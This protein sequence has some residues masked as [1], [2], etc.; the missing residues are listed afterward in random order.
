MLHGDE[1]EVKGKI[2]LYSHRNL[3]SFSAHH[4]N[5]QLL[6]RG[7]WTWNKQNVGFLVSS[8]IK[9][10]SWRTQKQLLQL[11]VNCCF[12]TSI[13]FNET[14]L[15]KLILRKMRSRGTNVSVVHMLNVLRSAKRLEESLSKLNCGFKRD[16]KRFPYNP[17]VKSSQS[18]PCT[19]FN[20]CAFM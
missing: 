18:P 15:R 8:R 17:G 3:R 10:G 11:S 5:C 6:P 2:N 12:I 19:V 1:G 16:L 13:T 14:E 20:R 4:R 7:W 9:K